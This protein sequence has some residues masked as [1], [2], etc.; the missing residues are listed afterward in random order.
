MD[1]VVFDG[2]ERE[3]LTSGNPYSR[4]CKGG[5]VWTSGHKTQSRAWFLHSKYTPSWLERN[6]LVIEKQ[7][8]DH[9]RRVVKARP[10]QKPDGRL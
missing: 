4:R 6:F 10:G 9:V 1:V 7:V 3:R 5:M 8:V 2:G